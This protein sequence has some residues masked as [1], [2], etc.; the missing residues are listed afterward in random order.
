[1]MKAAIAAMLSTVVIVLLAITAAY[2]QQANES[3]QP[4]TLNDYLDYA[5]LHN[6]SLKSSF[7]QWQD[8]LNEVPN[9]TILDPKLTYESYSSQTQTQGQQER[10][11]VGVSHTFELFGKKDAQ[12][13]EAQ[14]KAEAARLK[15]EADKLKLFCEVK[16]AFYQYAYL[17]K[18]AKIIREHLENFERFE[19]VRQCSFC[20]ADGFLDIILARAEM[21]RLEKTLDEFEQLKGHAKARFNEA[22]NRQLDAQITGYVPEE[23]EPIRLNH[24]LI[25]DMLR[26]RNPQLV[27]LDR[28]IEAARSGVRLA[29]AQAYPDIGVGVDFV[30]TERSLASGIRKDEKDPTFITFSLNLPLRQET[31]DA[32]QQ[33]ALVLARKKEQERIEAENS[34]L[35]G[36]VQVLYDYEDSSREIRLYRE[37]LADKLDSVKT[38]QNEYEAWSPNF[39]GFIEE[40]QIF[41]SY[42]LGYERAIARNRQ[43][44]AELE[45]LSGTNMDQN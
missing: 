34:I 20:T 44:L 9:R 3:N 25:V 22:L 37:L 45:M 12:T 24:T 5:Q 10:Q 41:L 43:K 4:A 35:A 30:R 11:K 36:V 19:Q 42:Q 38:M 18:A 1:M 33:Q 32:A 39:A 14:A 8:V 28:E 21:T 13:E 23:F 6:A 31:L 16:K 17:E 40:Q 2:A 27:Q 29:E 7:Q 26:M 15:F